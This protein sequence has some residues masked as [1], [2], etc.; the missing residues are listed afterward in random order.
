MSRWRED[1]NPAMS[2][3]AGQFSD[4]KGVRASLY[5]DYRGERA[6]TVNYDTPCLGYDDPSSPS[7]ALTLALTLTFAKHRFVFFLL[8]LSFSLGLQLSRRSGARD[9]LFQ[10]LGLF[11]RK[12]IKRCPRCRGGGSGSMRGGHLAR[13]RSS[14]RRASKIECGR[15]TAPRELCLRPRQRAGKRR[16]SARGINRSVCERRRGRRAATQRARNARLEHRVQPHHRLVR[17]HE[18]RPWELSLLQDPRRATS[19]GRH[20]RRGIGRLV[21]HARTAQL[22]LWTCGAARNIDLCDV[23]SRARAFPRRGRISVSRECVTAGE[24]LG[25]AGALPR[26]VF[27]QAFVAFQVVVAC[28]GGGASPAAEGPIGRVAARVSTEAVQPREGLAAAR[29]AARIHGRPRRVT[30]PGGGGRGTG[31]ATADGDAGEH[32]ER[33]DEAA[34]LL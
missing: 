8:E 22:V 28:K 9:R 4:A 10:H 26:P 6:S 27:V 33:L 18:H 23:G 21:P 32:A 25:A 20:R 5:A 14:R 7:F 1:A 29:K 17:S 13:G 31:A 11:W 30:R 15:T 12:A 3:R 2:K 34:E 24:G 19:T 16:L